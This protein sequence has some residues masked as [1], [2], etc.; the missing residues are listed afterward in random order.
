MI[1]P[2]AAFLFVSTNKLSAL[3][4]Y[5]LEKVACCTILKTAYL[6]SHTNEKL[7]DIQT[8]SLIQILS[9]LDSISHHIISLYLFISLPHFFPVQSI[10]GHHSLRGIILNGSFAKGHC[11]LDGKRMTANFS[12]ALKNKAPLPFWQSHIIHETVHFNHKA[13]YK[14]Y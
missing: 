13:C 1:G 2:G 9:L 11:H 3:H 5:P 14:S 6:C 7:S 10:S 8:S 12:P 4:C